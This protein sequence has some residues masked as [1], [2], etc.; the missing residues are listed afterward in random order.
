MGHGVEREIINYLAEKFNLQ[1]Y[2][3]KQSGRFQIGSSRALSRARDDQGVDV[4]F[5]NDVPK[6]LS[7]WAIQVKRSETTARSSTPIDLKGLLNIIDE[8]HPLLITKVM[9]KANVRAN[10]V[11]T[12]ATMELDELVALLQRI[13]EL[14]QNDRLVDNTKALREAFLAGAKAITNRMAHKTRPLMGQK[15]DLDYDFDDFLETFQNQKNDD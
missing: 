8:E 9:R 12:F 14:E 1:V 2:N 13:I 10:A 3:P 11:G 5:S 4:M 6:I 7:Q 15:A